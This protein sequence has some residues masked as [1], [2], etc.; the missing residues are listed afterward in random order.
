[1]AT[2]DRILP[3]CDIFLGAAYADKEFHD[4]EREEVRAML[5][6]LA[7]S[8]TPELETRITGFDPKKFDLAK[9]AAAFKTDPPDDRRRLLFLVA[10][11]NEADEEVDLAED[12][13]LRALAAA[14]DLP[15]EALDGMVLDVEI[16]ELKED[17]QKVRKGPPPPPG[18]KGNGSVDIDL[19]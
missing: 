4:R 14:L 13:Y 3:L 17:F 8:L 5:A 7:G 6:D 12:E 9:T 11:I 18:K 2:P 1:M 10:A 19:D 16:E 15:P